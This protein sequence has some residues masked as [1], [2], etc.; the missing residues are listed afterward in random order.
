MDSLSKESEKEK[1]PIYISWVFCFFNFFYFAIIIFL[2][3]DILWI[4][5]I[6]IAFLILELST[7]I[8][9]TIGIVKGIYNLYLAGALLCLISK[10][11]FSIVLVMMPLNLYSLIITLIEWIQFISLAMDNAKVK[12]SLDKSYL[13]GNLI[14]NNL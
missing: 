5:I 10:L 12:E 8:L 13:E 14:N 2:P 7:A 6:V 3:Y 11:L 4:K 1:Y 9:V